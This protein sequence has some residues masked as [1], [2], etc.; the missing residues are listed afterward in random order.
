[1]QEPRELT[2]VAAINLMRRGDLTAQELVKS[3]LERIHQ[4]EG[5]I[6]AWG[7]VYEDEAL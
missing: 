6:H 1:M 5:T 2:I 4:R 3:C 7:E